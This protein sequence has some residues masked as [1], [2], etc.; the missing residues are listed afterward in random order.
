MMLKRVHLGSLMLSLFAAGAAALAPVPVM[1][2]S[3]PPS[4]EGSL[5]KARVDGKYRMLLRQ[6]KVEKDAESYGAFKDLGF[7]DRKE[8]AGRTD[9]PR[10]FWV[11]VKP[12]WYIWRDLTSVQR[13][14]RP[15]GPEQVTGEPDTSEAGDIQTAWASASQDDQDE[16]L[17]VE[18][19]EPIVPTA[20][21]VYETFNPGALYRI[22]VFKLNGEEVE[23]WKGDDPTTAGSD[24]GVSQVPIK[25][26]FKTNR[27]KL[28][29]A[30]KAVAGWNEIDAVGLHDKTRTYWAVAA[31]ASS[32]YAPPFGET[33]NALPA[34]EERL[35]LLE[36]EVR[37]LKA[38]V[39][40]LTKQLKKQKNR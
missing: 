30:S 4:L 14:R 22:T 27:V 13:P 37:V 38:Q 34:Q 33:Q 20:V 23:V 36:E 1:A 8:Y 40:E 17:M 3:A 2:A 11:Y 10:G 31:E 21:D 12:Y 19:D 39:A 29:L 35:R 24:K 15:W 5:T 28:Y 7:R 16:W 25:V 6:F 9:L 26:N 32:T 18:Y